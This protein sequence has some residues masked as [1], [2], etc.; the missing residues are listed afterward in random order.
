LKLIALPLAAL[1]LLSGIL[2]LKRRLWPAVSF[3]VLIAS[4]IAAVAASWVARAVFAREAFLL[5]YGR[6]ALREL[7][8]NA[9]VLIVALIAIVTSLLSLKGQRWL[10]LV[11]WL[12]TGALLALLIY[13]AFFFKIF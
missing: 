5:R 2:A 4:P 3:N 13:L 7:P 8:F 1:W 6:A 10:F 11:G 9:A 12:A